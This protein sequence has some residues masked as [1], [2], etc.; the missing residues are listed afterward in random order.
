MAKSESIESLISA[1]GMISS[2]HE[3]GIKFMKPLLS[4]E[5]FSIDFMFKCKKDCEIEL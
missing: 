2:L 5:I 1:L 4:S 3:A